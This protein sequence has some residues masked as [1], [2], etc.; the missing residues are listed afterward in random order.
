MG[1]SLLSVLT[2]KTQFSHDRWASHFQ[3]GI[4][5]VLIQVCL[6]RINWS[7]CGN[8]NN[9]REKLV[10]RNIQKL[11]I[12]DKRQHYQDVRY[13]SD[14]EAAW[15]FFSFPMVEH[16]SGA[17]HYDLAKV[18]EK[19]VARMYNISARI[20]ERYCLS[21]LLL[22]E[23][24]A[25]SFSDML[26]HGKSIIDVPKNMLHDRASLWWCRMDTMNYRLFLFKIQSFYRSL[27]RDFDILLTF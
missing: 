20:G 27:Y 23:T 18:L 9:S 11:P 22:N 5:T 16:P 4:D 15:R 8:L 7:Y 24:G 12:I 3:S 19:F 2:P 6:R 26:A 13:I 25:T 10:S 21:T 14:S 1:S 17:A